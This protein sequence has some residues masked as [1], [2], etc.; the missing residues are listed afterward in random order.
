MLRRKRGASCFEGARV[1]GI[2]TRSLE[3][4]FH[5]FAHDY[6]VPRRF[7]CEE[8]GLAA[9]VVLGDCPAQIQGGSATD[10]SRQSVVTKTAA[11][12]H[13]N[14]SEM[15]HDVLIGHDQAKGANSQGQEPLF[16]L[17]M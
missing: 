7:T 13:W 14:I 15:P 6:T 2:G 11:V 4:Q 5:R 1:R 16:V 9:V 17:D 12:S 3:H 8:A 10:H